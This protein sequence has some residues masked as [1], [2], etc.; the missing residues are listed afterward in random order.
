MKDQITRIEAQLKELETLTKSFASN[1]D[2][3]E[4]LRIIHQPGWT[5]IAEGQLVL[6]LTEATIANVRQAAHLRQE[7]LKAAKAVGTPTPVGVN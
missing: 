6:A 3:Q 4:L 1:Q 5:T 2:T 7:L